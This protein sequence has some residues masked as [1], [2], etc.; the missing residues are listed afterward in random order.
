MNV[1]VTNDFGLNVQEFAKARKA[2]VLGKLT[3]LQWDRA[4]SYQKGVLRHID[5]A[6]KSVTMDDLSELDESDQ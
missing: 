1:E 4:N 6:I 3:E 5:L 2:M